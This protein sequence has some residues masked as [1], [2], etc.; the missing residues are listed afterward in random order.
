MED[1]CYCHYM[2]RY[3]NLIHNK[4]N[5]SHNKN[6][7]SHNKNKLINNKNN[8]VKKTINNN[9]LSHKQ[10]AYQNSQS[11]NSPHHLHYLNHL[12]FDE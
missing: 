11:V 6:N 3:Y 5:L 10:C 9:Q 4:N 8:E 7:L 1:F 12:L 2:E